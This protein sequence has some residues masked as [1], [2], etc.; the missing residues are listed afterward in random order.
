MRRPNG[1]DLRAFQ[2]DLF[3]IP[4]RGNIGIMPPA[5]AEKI[6]GI[7]A[8]Q[9]INRRKKGVRRA[10]AKVT[11]AEPDREQHERIR[12]AQVAMV[13]AMRGD[14]DRI[15]ESTQELLLAVVA[16][17]HTGTIPHCDY[18][19]AMQAARLEARG[20]ST[21]APSRNPYAWGAPLHSGW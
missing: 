21:P 17:L 3:L 5:V 2:A 10:L 4:M 9:S 6:D 19:A 20:P 1:I 7:L 16:G 15:A 8:E 14:W 12:E 18:V 13:R 11:P